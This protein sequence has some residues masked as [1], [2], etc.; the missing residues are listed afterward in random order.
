MIIGVE[1]VSSTTALSLK[2]AI[3]HLFLRFKVYMY[4]KMSRL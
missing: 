4:F 1:Y 2:V 3:D